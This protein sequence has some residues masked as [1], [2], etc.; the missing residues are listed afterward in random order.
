MYL[1]VQDIL[2]KPF[3]VGSSE[4]ECLCFL[5]ISEDSVFDAIHY[6]VTRNNVITTILG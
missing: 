6:S 4:L 3:P 5:Y 2:K 1:E